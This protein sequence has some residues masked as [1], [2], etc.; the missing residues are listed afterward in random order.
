VLDAAPGAHRVEEIMGMPIGIDVRDSVVADGALD[1]AFAVMRRA[2]ALFSTY[3]A[4]SEISR[5]NAGDLRLDDCTADVQDVVAQCEALRT[6]TAGYFNAYAKGML[7][8]SGLV[9]GWA[10]ERAHE[11][12][13]R[14]G[15]RHGCINAA[16]DVRVWGGRADGEPWRVGIRDPLHADRISAVET[17]HDGAVAT[18]G[19]YERG[20]HIVDP[21]TGRPAHGALSVTVTGPDLATADAYATA[22][23]AAGSGQA[24][25]FTEQVGYRAMT[26][27]SSADHDRR[28]VTL[29]DDPQ[30]VAA[31]P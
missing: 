31:R 26:I 24:D 19:A 15:V 12:L 28:G 27:V 21:H 17:L 6:R 22:L 13:V 9:K 4:D 23:F 1:D 10:V 3:R 5:V 2:D 8:P 7:D 25:W 20:D 30:G 16:G 18:S 29:A 14:A 11:T